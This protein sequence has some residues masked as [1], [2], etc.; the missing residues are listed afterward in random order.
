M[1]VPLYLDVYRYVHDSNLISLEFL[2]KGGE[3]GGGANNTFF[4]LLSS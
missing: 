2:L 3:G 4:I 1:Y